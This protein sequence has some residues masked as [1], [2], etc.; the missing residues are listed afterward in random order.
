MGAAI[1]TLACQ[2][3]AAAIG[4][5]ILRMGFHG[6]HVRRSDFIPDPKHI[7]RAFFLGLPASIELSARALGLMVMTFVVTSF[8][9]L[10]LAAYGVG[11]NILQVI[12][13]P[14]MGLSM[15]VS[16]LAGQNIG[17]GNVARAASIGRLGALLGFGSLTLLGM[18]VF[19]FSTQLVAFFV[20]RDAEV[21]REGSLFLRIMCLSWGFIGAQFAFAGVFRASG[22]MVVNMTL[23][24]SS[25]WLLQLPLAYVLS[26]HTSLGAEGIYW[27]MPI[28]NVTTALVTGAVYAHGGW[29]KKRLINKEEIKVTEEILED[30]GIH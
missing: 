1:T 2:S 19:L 10:S 3:I 20:P 11:G 12:I 24:I 22:N 26:K 15:A 14:A 27:A 5:A 4:I 18:V 7:K 13:I 29:R 6:I 8:G 25:Q 30:E 17:A 28:A 21:I 23:T 9:T 16:A